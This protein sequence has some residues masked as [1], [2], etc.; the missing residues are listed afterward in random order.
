MHVTRFEIF[1]EETCVIIYCTLF[2]H[3]VIIS[4][5]WLLCHLFAVALVGLE[6]TFSQVTESVDVLELCIIANFSGDDCLLTFSFNVIISTH[7]GTA[8]T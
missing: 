1:N 2:M 4:E 7:D 3:D 5:C 8:G 6:T